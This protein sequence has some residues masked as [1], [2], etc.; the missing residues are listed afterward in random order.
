[1]NVLVTGGA[2]YI[3]SH[4]A[5]ALANAGH[6]PIVYDDLS[7]GHRWAVRWGPFVQG[8][9]GDSRLI[10]STLEAHKIE[11]ILHFAAFA[12]VGESMAQPGRYFE[13][14][15]SKSLALMEAARNAGVRYFVF[16][17]SCAT[18]GNPE[19]LPMAEDHPQLPVNPYGESKLFVEK[20]LRWYGHAHDLRWAA[21]RYFNAA[22]ADPDGELGEQHTPETHLIPLVLEAAANPRAPVHVF[23]DDYL[24]KDGTAIRDYIHVADLAAGHVAALQYLVDGGASRA[25]NLGTGCGS[26]VTEVIHCV[27]SVTGLSPSVIVDKRRDGDPAELVADVTSARVILGW[28]PFRSNLFQIVTDAWRWRLAVSIP[29]SERPRSSVD[30]LLTSVSAEAV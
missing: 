14:N 29:P 23:G 27:R 3:G 12:Y 13:N 19:K 30:E 16:S 15:A 11:A 1:M 25:F 6:L 28:Q 20:L 21:L 10:K 26:S 9:I 18:Y 4:T 8:D 7:R 22:G 2:G 5:K 17:S 24:T